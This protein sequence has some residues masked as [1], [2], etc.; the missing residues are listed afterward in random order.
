[1]AFRTRPD[2]NRDRWER[3]GLDRA[4]PIDRQD[5]MMRMRLEL[6]DCEGGVQKQW[7]KR[8]VL[9]NRLY[10]NCL[11]SIITKPIKGSLIPPR[12]QYCLLKI[13]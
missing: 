7:D 1:M 13:S 9:F 2:E 4:G 5:V 11:I 8:H 10:S 6:H 12:F 3:P